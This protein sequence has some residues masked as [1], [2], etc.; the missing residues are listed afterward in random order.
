MI[1]TQNSEVITV[2]NII[3]SPEKDL[4]DDLVS[5]IHVFSCRI[6]GLRKYARKVKKYDK[7]S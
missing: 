1:P 3:S 2:E 6:Y 4:I 7:D 5:I